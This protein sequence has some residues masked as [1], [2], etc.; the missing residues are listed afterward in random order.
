MIV[1]EQHVLVSGEVWGFSDIVVIIICHHS[2][3]ALM[4][5]HGSA[6]RVTALVR[7]FSSRSSSCFRKFLETHQSLRAACAVKHGLERE[8]RVCSANPVKPAVSWA[9]Q[10]RALSSEVSRRFQFVNKP[11]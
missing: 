8:S 5:A 3:L 7:H 10:H 11:M 6:A 2:P 4:A 9:T 1:S